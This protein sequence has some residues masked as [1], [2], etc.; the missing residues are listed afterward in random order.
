VPVWEVGQLRLNPRQRA[1]VRDANPL[2]LVCISPPGVVPSM[3]DSD[4]A[5][6]TE[7]VHTIRRGPRWT[8]F[9]NPIEYGACRPLISNLFQV[10]S[11][12]SST[13]TYPSTTHAFLFFFFFAG[14]VLRFRKLL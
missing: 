4:E 10:H 6:M 7:L 1:R 5:F 2:V 8:V 13:P 9:G 12:S 3:P 14:A 11:N